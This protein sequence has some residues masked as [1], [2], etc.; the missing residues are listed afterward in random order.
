MYEVLLNPNFEETKYFIERNLSKSLITILAECEIL[1]EGRAF[2]KASSSRRLIIVK[3]DGSVIVHESTKREPINWQPPGSRIEVS[4]ESEVF[5]IKAIRKRPKEKLEILV[6][7]VF[8]ITSSVV[9]E[10]D[11]MLVGSEKD[12]VDLV[13]S[14]PELIEEGFKPLQREY[15][16]PYGKIDLLGKDNKG[17]YV[18]L[19]FKRAKAT[20]QAVSQL[21]RY[22][23]YFR[24][25]GQLVRGILVAPGISENALN[26]L[27]RLVLEY[28]DL[29]SIIDFTNNGRHTVTLSN[30]K[31]NQA[32]EIGQRGL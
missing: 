26:L 14:K 32:Q 11:F 30:S 9:E 28:V 22:V 6:S 27:R 24:E 8:F 23:M 17:N 12:E 16:T 10:G 18:V 3:A 15:S 4:I 1:Y 7:R 13:I 19:E 20:L 25:R 21:Y 5:K 31:G 2:S 29:R